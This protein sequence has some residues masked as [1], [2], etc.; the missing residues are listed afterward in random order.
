[1]LQVKSYSDGYHTIRLVKLSDGR[2]QVQLDNKGI[3]FPTASYTR[4]SYQFDGV[5][6]WDTVIKCA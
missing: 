5:I 2:Y 4:A 3:Y 6:G 1:M